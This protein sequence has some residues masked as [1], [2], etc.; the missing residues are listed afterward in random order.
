MGSRVDYDAPGQGCTRMLYNADGSILFSCGTSKDADSF[1]V[2]WNETE[3]A[4]KRTYSGFRKISVVKYIPYEKYFF[5][6]YLFDI[7]PLKMVFEPF[8]RGN[9]GN[10]VERDCDGQGSVWWNEFSFHSLNHSRPHLVEF[11]DSDEL[12]I[13]VHDAGGI[14]PVINHSPW[15][16]L[17]L[18]DFVMPFFLFIVGIS[19]ALIDKNLSCRAVATRKTIPRALKLLMLGLFLQD[20]FFHGLNDLTYGVD[21]EHMRWMGILHRIA[22][23]Y[24]L[25]S[26][27]EIWRKGDVYCSNSHNRVLSAG[28]DGQVILYK[29]SSETVEPNITK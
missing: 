9:E 16:G 1:L 11:I 7:L 14:L 23:A 25:A 8:D 20:G 13:F 26:L 12:M 19:L 3:G 21:I 27:C 15:D 18:A 5:A 24:L 10:L 28:S 22:I 29:L 17:T 6:H 2:E 4:I